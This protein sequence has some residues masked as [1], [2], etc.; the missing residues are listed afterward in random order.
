MPP[1]RMTFSAIQK[2]NAE[3]PMEIPILG[4]GRARVKSG[5]YRT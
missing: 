4:Q 5:Q 3:V 2:K 1:A